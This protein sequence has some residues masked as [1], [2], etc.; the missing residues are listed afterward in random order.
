MKKSSLEVELGQE[1][2]ENSVLKL[3]SSNLATEG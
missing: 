1:L 2:G 3:P